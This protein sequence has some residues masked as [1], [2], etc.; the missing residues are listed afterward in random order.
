MFSELLSLAADAIHAAGAAL[1]P[2]AEPV[3]V[4][5]P[6]GQEVYMH[7]L[8]AET[9]VHLLCCRLEGAPAAPKQEAEGAS[10]PLIEAAPLHLNMCVQPEVLR[11]RSVWTQVG[12][13]IGSNQCSR[14][15]RRLRRRRCRS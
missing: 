9:V 14:S 8:V 11:G 15:F 7:L 6:A 5:D 4:W 13:S 12:L 10:D 3:P 2:L 1:R